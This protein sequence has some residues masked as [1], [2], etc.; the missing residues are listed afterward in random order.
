M[1]YLLDANVLIALID[2][3]HIH[4]DVAHEWF[5][6][7]GGERLGYLSHHRKRRFT[8]YWPPKLSQLAR[9]SRCGGALLARYARTRR[10]C[11]LERWWSKIPLS[12][13]LGRSSLLFGQCLSQQ[14]P[15]PQLFGIG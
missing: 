3:G 7:D 12:D 11:I 1:T 13:R 15:M 10:T 4:H 9:E 6:R 2:P 14:Y 8:Y 5:A